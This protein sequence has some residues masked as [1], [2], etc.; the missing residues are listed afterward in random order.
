MR[1]AP[2]GFLAAVAAIMA[3]GLA[4]RLWGTTAGL[5]YVYNVD[6]GAHFVPRAIGM[7]DHSYDP[8]YFINPPGLT[9]VLHALFWLRWGGERTLE[10]IGAAP[11]TVFGF[12]RDVVAVLGT[13]AVGAMAW[14]GARLFDRRV[15]LVAAA[16]MAVAFLPVHYGHFAL[17]DAVLLLP[18][19]IALGAT[20]GVLARGR[21]RDYLLAG[22]AVGLA[23]AVKY[24]AGIVLVAL[25]AAA[26]VGPGD[27]R[28]RAR[29]LALAALAAAAGF[30]AL[31]PYAL[32]SF[33]EFR[34]GLGEQS[35]ASS[36][37]GKLGLDPV[38]PLRYYLGTLTW[39]LGVAP[40][41]AAVGGGIA[42]W[43]RRYRLAMVLLPAP[44]LF[45][46]FMGAQDRFFARWALPVY[47]FLILLAAWGA[48]ALLERARRLPAWAVVALAAAALGAQGLVY[49]V[50]NDIVL[51][52]TDTREDAR[53]WML[54]HIPAGARVVIEPIAP[55]GWGDPWV[56]RATSHFVFDSAGNKSLLRKPKLED[57]PRTLRPDLI[58]SY[59]RSGDCWVVTGSIISGRASVAP[60]RAPM[61]VRY[62]ERLRRAG[63]VVY[64][65][66]PFAAGAEPVGFSFDDSYNHRPLAY[67]RPG[68]EIVIHRLHGGDCA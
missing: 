40:L 47:P 44:L 48:V 41:L 50:H 38:H 24:T 36:E 35:A 12:S 59:L 15:A 53:A 6:E 1:A 66:S 4:L 37:S 26:L 55:D 9:Y 46:A 61:A 39:G 49:V 52:R 32:L 27:R 62:Y 65:V 3:G 20:A 21:R 29:G 13:L 8:G 18:V 11:G 67:E 33:D 58:G 5:P 22:A 56:K 25:I 34:R 19:C 57:Y 63:D 31:N 43:L 7:F 54:E 10:L 14:A 42:L 64:R 23:A 30:L 16:L 45:F 51:T 28:A 2:K 60:E 68:P 17:N